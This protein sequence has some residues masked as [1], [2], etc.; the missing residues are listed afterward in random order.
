MILFNLF[1]KFIGARA[2]GVL[3]EVLKVAAIVAVLAFVPWLDTSRVRSTKYRPIYKWFFWLF[4]FTCLALGYLG[5]KPAEGVYVFW[6]QIFTL[7]YFVHFLIVMP[8]VGLI[9][10]P[11][12]MPRSIN[13]AV[14]GKS[15][16]GAAL[17]A[18]AAAAPETR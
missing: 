11:K 13:E 15:A 9:E 7:Y 2:A 12:N 4:A 14:L 16:G 3:I 10:T 6:A 8:I 5:S 18:G 17:P 1:A